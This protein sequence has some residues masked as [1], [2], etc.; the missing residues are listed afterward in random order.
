MLRRAL[1]SG[2][3]TTLGLLFLPAGAPAALTADYRFE[4]NLRSSV[5]GV[6]KLAVDGPG[7]VG[8][9]EEQVRTSEQGVLTWPEGTGLRLDDARDALGGAKGDYTITMLVN[10][11]DVSAYNKLIA[12]KGPNSDDGLYAYFGGLYPYGPSRDEYTEDVFEAGKWVQIT[13]AR[14]RE[15]KLKCFVGKELQVRVGDPDRTHVVNNAESLIFLR[16]DVVGGTEETG[17]RIARLRIWDNA[18]SDE[19]IEDLGL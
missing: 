8:F 14:N 12:F 6:S 4:G 10:L 7:P 18:L 13:L 11:D 19:R 2:V 17:G 16:D 9:S 15:G 1:V 3:V 5:P